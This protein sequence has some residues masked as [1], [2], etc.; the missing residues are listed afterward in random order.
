[1]INAI[2]EAVKYIAT[3]PSPDVVREIRYLEA[4]N[5]PGEVCWSELDILPDT[6]MVKVGTITSGKLAQMLANELQRW[7]DSWEQDKRKWGNRLGVLCEARDMLRIINAKDRDLATKRLIER[8][9]DAIHGTRKD[10]R[11]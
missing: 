1:M 4:T 8:V 2:E 9:D 7:R 3:H 6:G 5:G 10:I 11:Q